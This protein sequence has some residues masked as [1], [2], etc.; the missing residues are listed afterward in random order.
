MEF[1]KLTF[2]RIWV[3]RGGLLF[4]NSSRSG[5]G[6]HIVCRASVEELRCCLQPSLKIRSAVID[7]KQQPKQ[8][9]YQHNVS[10]GIFLDGKPPSRRVRVKEIYQIIVWNRNEID[11]KKFLPPGFM[12][13]R[14][15]SAV[16]LIYTFI[17]YKQTQWCYRFYHYDITI[18]RPFYQRV[19]PLNDECR[20]W[21]SGRLGGCARPFSPSLSYTQYIFNVI[22]TSTSIIHIPCTGDII[23]CVQHAEDFRKML[24]ICCYFT[25]IISWRLTVSCYQLNIHVSAS[26]SCRCGI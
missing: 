22:G 4:A 13:W 18:R 21:V 3:Y 24:I 26:Q 9:L 7:H 6:V 17:T 15:F 12:W 2:F 1:I 16:Q 14:M 20:G 25:Q 19:Q 5:R 10:I 23:L 11:K 8:Q